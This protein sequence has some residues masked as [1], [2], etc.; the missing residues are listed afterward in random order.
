MKIISPDDLVCMDDAAQNGGFRVDIA[1]ARD[2]NT[3]FGER[4][5]RTDAKLYLH[6]DLAS[7]VIRAARLCLDETGL[8]FVLYD[9]LRPVEAQEAMLST[10]RVISNPHWLEEPRLLSPPGAGGHPRGM[11]IDI[12]LETA[13]G[14]LLDMGTVFDFL[15]ED[16]H[17]EFNPAHRNYKGHSKDIM[18]N[19]NVLDSYMA[20]AAEALD[21]LLFPLPQEWWDFRLPPEI[22]S[23]Y[24]PIRDTDLPEHMRLTDI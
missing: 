2:D 20:R 1:Y 23:Q 6:K 13:E 19:R 17:A 11:A 14:A 21:I 15:A 3:L 24:A 10:A 18:D 9:G 16:P 22:Y 7:I 8:R 12:G 5:Y 4:V